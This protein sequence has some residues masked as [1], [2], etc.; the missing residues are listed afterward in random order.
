MNIE[1][2]PV[3]AE[4]KTKEDNNPL[5]A[6]QKRLETLPLAVQQSLGALL[7]FDNP[8]LLL[9]T[10]MG[11][12]WTPEAEITELLNLANQDDKL[13]TKLA[14]IKE[15]RAIRRQMLQDY[16]A[17]VSVSGTQKD[18]DGN[19]VTVSADVTAKVLTDL[20]THMKNKDN[21]NE[22]TREHESG[23]VSEDCSFEEGTGIEEERGEGERGEEDSRGE[24]TQ[25]LTAGDRQDGGESDYQ[26][27]SGRELTTNKQT[28][29]G[30]ASIDSPRAKISKQPA[31]QHNAG[32]LGSGTL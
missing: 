24:D 20:R 25:G 30:P 10:L 2:L 4:T 28:I 18:E 8:S 9:N 26:P 31:S 17:Y 19:T 5:S 16:G 12:G 6:I 29:K 7:Q 23:R 27:P 32:G 21:N 11:N 3:Y 22:I 13:P 14:A 1:D 15:L